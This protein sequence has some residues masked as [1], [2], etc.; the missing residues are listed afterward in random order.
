MQKEQ[1]NKKN[2]LSRQLLVLRTCLEFRLLFLKMEIDLIMCN[3][4]GLPEPTIEMPSASASSSSSR[5]R[6]S[7]SSS[8]SRIRNSSSSVRSSISWFGRVYNSYI[9]VPASQTI[10]TRNESLQGF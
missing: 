8:C 6:G 4:V 1:Q 10:L 7:S 2:L 5:G 9:E 3:V